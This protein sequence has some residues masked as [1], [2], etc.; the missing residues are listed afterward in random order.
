M[1]A[2]CYLI[3]YAIP[4]TNWTYERKIGARQRED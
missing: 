2:T 1:L 4:K 3:S